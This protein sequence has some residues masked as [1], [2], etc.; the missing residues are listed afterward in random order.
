MLNWITKFLK[1][2]EQ[3]S[4]LI[5]PLSASAKF[6]LKYGALPIGYLKV[7]DGKWTFTYSEDF[8]S[9][10]S[11]DVLTDFPDKNRVYQSDNLWPFFAHRIPG[12]GQPQIRSIMEKE[13]INENNEVDL[14][15]R[16]GRKTIA[17]PFELATSY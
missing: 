17:N 4:K 9:Q 7:A 5:V 15:K 1:N 14:L 6:E 2:E 12:L 8:R 11:I 16:F 10:D 3:E 13:N